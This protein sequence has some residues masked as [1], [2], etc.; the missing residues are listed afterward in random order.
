[1]DYNN[2]SVVSSAIQGLVD[3]GDYSATLYLIDLLEKTSNH[4]IRNQV[5]LALRDIGDARAVRP[6]VN[7]L[8]DPKTRNHRGTLI[9]SLSVFDCSQIL[10]LLV[11]LVISGGFEVSREAFLIIENMEGEI[12]KE[13]WHQCKNK[14]KESLQNTSNGDKVEILNELYSLFNESDI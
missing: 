6:I 4:A 14:V 9:Y 3:L 7:L 13:V 11:E 10:P 8:T 12:E 5:A 2:Y 1:M